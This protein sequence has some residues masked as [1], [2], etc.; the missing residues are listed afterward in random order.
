M[1]T[2]FRPFQP[3]QTHL[4]PPAPV[5]WLPE[6][7]LAFFIADT[8]S[9]L[10]LS[11]FYRP[12]RGDG[13]R[14]RPFD[15][16]MMVQVLLY[17]Y[18]NGVFSSRRIAAKLHEDIAFRYLAAENFPKHRTISDFRLR[19]LEEFE[20]LFTQTV[21]IA[22]QA[23][24]VKMGTIAIDG[25][26]VKAN[27]TKHKAMSY[28]RMV[29]QEKRLQEEIRELTDRASRMDQEEDEQFGPDD[30][31]GGIPEELHRRETRLER[32][33]EAKDR[34]EGEERELDRQKGRH[35]NDDRKTPPG[36]G[37]RYKRDF[38]V[39]EEKKQTNFTDPES[40]IMKDSRG[41]EQCYNTQ[42]AVDEETRIIVGQGVSQI[43][44]D[45]CE[46]L[47]MLEEAERVT[48][49]APRQVLADAGYKSE[50]NF[51]QLADRGI[52]ALVALG[53]ERKVAEGIS[54]EQT[55]TRAMAERLSTEEGRRTYRK[56][57]HIVEPV[58]GWIKARMGLG[59]F[60]LRGLRK[61][62]GEWSL[63]TLACNI[64]RLSRLM[65]VF[66]T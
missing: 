18:A 64:R 17:A 50:E 13:R 11:A 56:R 31:G 54:P 12:Y 62:R 55:A 2:T 8:V 41:F 38:G 59:S 65:A 52:E 15:P 39:P 45:A 5:D 61:A 16:R 58:F 43:A 46:L 66:Q 20:A 14:N 25:S 44:A 1:G 35:E 30:A 63:V 60:S 10:D 51:Q 27:A 28:G 40:R 22:Q 24:L 6:G 36:R 48:G 47:P 9:Q 53:R 7:H 3:N 26:K 19:H 34:L 49:A 21:R 32:I 33:R 42:I 29:E 4:L 57:K 23:G 37:G